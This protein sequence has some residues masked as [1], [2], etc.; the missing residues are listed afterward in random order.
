MRGRSGR[1]GE[2]AWVFGDVWRTGAPGA[3]RETLGGG[4]GG[5][6]VERGLWVMVATERRFSRTAAC[7]E[8]VSICG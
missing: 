7:G 3:T 1:A 2:A 8:G 6:G 5:G 4:G